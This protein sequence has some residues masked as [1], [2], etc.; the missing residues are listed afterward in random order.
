VLREELRGI[1]EA[2]LKVDAA[3]KPKITFVVVQK[4]HHTRF[5]PANPDEGCGRAKNVFPGTVLDNAILF[6]EDFNFYLCSHA[7]IQG[8]SRPT[9]YHVLHDD[10]LFS[11]DEMQSLTYYLC[12]C[13]SRCTRAVSI[14]APVYYAH[15]ACTRSRAHLISV[16]GDAFSDTASTRSGEQGHTSSVPEEQLIKGATVMDNIRKEMYFT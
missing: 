15:L 9:R 2:C 13:F 11:P 5:F 16:V 4:R 6:H 10:N 3:F 7:G 12:H 8:T 14:P 1:R